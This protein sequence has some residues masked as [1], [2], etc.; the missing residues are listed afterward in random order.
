MYGGPQ[1]HT[2]YHHTPN[3]QPPFLFGSPASNAFRGGPR[4]RGGPHPTIDPVVIGRA[5]KEATCFDKESLNR[6]MKMRVPTMGP[7][8]DFKSCKRSF[9]T[10]LS[11]KAAY[12][13]LE[14]V[15][16]ESGLWLDEDAQTYA[17]AMLLHATSDNKRADRG[18]KC[19][20]D[21]R[22]DCAT[23]AWD[24]MCERLDGRSFAPWLSLL[25]NLMLRQRPG[26]SLTEYAHFMRQTFDDHNETCEMI[27]GFAAIHPHNSGILMLRGISSTGHFGLAKQCVI[28]AF[29]TSYLLSADEV[30]ANILHLA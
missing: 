29:D 12:L 5:V 4:E 20:Y 3:G 9:L 10:S 24:I 28:N 30:M 6:P 13:I 22:P 27:D 26:Q 7:N 8:M 1:S 11:M 15:V 14:L 17:Y 18:V 2:G 25:N 19:V 16:R 23:A 21:A